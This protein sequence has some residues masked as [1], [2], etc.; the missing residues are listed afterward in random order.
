MQV[1]LKAELLKSH[2]S[3]KR[4][5]G[6]LVQTTMQ[7]PLWSNKLTGFVEW[8]G[9]DQTGVYWLTDL[10]EVPFVIDEQEYPA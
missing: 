2:P 10:E 7:D 1:R 8:E 9:D 6:R 5:V 4:A 3:A